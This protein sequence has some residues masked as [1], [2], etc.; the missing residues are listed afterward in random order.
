VFE[1]CS[2]GVMKCFSCCILHWCRFSSYYWVLIM[3]R[4]GF[5][6]SGNI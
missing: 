1:Q 5:C 6:P 2:E 3:K 4:K